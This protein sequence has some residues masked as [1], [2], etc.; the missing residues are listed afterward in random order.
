[1]TA[2]TGNIET[3][4][5]QWPTKVSPKPMEVFKRKLANFH[6]LL[7]PTKKTWKSVTFV[8]Q[9]QMK[10]TTVTSVDPPLTDERYGHNFVGYGRSMKVT[11]FFYI[12]EN[13]TASGANSYN[14]Q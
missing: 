12:I 11:D 13:T 3:S 10:V 7:L 8:G 5:G 1:L 9:W 6:W 14:T 4:I 2:T